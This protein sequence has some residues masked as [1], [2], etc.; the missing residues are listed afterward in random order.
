MN[1]LPQIVNAPAPG[2]NW[3]TACPRFARSLETTPPAPAKTSGS[4]AAGG[5]DGTAPLSRRQFA[6]VENFASPPAPVQTY[7][8][9]LATV[10]RA[11]TQ[12][13]DTPDRSGS[14]AV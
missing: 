10:T 13:F 12:R 4:P 7:A 14:K 2:S 9:L 8:E 5:T 3:T 11:A 6:S 1:G